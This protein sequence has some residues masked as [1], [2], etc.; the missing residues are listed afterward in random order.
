M[1]DLYSSTVNIAEIHVKVAQM[2]PVQPYR[3]P[4]K[5]SAK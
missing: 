5:E 1:T 4:R 2:G 3:S